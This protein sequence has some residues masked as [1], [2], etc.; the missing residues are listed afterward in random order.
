MK[1]LTIAFILLFFSP[2][3]KA[4]IDRTTKTV[5]K[6]LYSPING[7]YYNRDRKGAIAKVFVSNGDSIHV[8]GFCTPKYCDWGT[9]KMGKNGNAFYAVYVESFKKVDLEMYFSDTAVIINSH[10]VF[11]DGRPEQSF[12]E[13]LKKS[14]RNRK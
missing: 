2:D 7:T 9:A 8:Y 12:K 13:Y 3:L 11:N 14:K 10:T 4:Q 6:S 1:Y 5:N